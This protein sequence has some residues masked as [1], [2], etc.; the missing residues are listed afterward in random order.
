MPQSSRTM[1]IRARVAEV[2]KAAKARG[3]GATKLAKACSVERNQVYRWEREENVP[4]LESAPA[5]AR[6]GGVS[7]S[8]LACLD[9]T[10]LEEGVL[11]ALRSMPLEARR[12]VASFPPFGLAKS[13]TPDSA[14]ALSSK[15]G[16][17]VVGWREVREARSAAEETRLIWSGRSGRQRSRKE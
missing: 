3:I 2:V 15:P 17:R 10:E 5:L 6:A 11:L 13:A 4:S 14:V 9:E 16:A 12:E 8:Y 7:L 1:D